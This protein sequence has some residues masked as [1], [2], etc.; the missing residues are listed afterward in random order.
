[1]YNGAK[2]CA[3]HDQRVQS[4]AFECLLDAGRLR[5]LQE[6]LI[7]I[8]DPDKD[9]LRKYNLGSNY[10]NRVKHIGAKEPYDPSY[11]LMI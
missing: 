5:L 9:S 7:S 2:A 1:L 10:K 8:I 3:A 4:S 11:A 6:K